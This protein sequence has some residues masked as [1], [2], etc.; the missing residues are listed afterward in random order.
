MAFLRPDPTTFRERLN[1]MSRREWLFAAAAIVLTL[2]VMTGF[3][4]ESR[5]GYPK[6][7]P[8][9]IYVESWPSSGSL[10]DIRLPSAEPSRVAPPS[11]ARDER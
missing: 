3:L 1:A 4:I 2:I 11:E 6:P 5:Y 7:A 9:V 10:A 8:R